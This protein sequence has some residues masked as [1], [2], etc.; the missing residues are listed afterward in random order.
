MANPALND[1]TFRNTV[2]L[3]FNAINGALQ[4]GLQRSGELPTDPRMHPAPPGDSGPPQGQP[5]YGPNADDYK[6]KLA[7]LQAR[8]YE[9]WPFVEQLLDAS[10]EDTT[11]IIDQL[12]AAS[13][14]L[15]REAPSRGFE[16]ITRIKDNCVWEGD[17]GDDFRRSYLDPLARTLQCQYEAMVSLRDLTF[18]HREIVLA[19]R[20]GLLEILDEALV[21]FKALPAQEREAY[22]EKRRQNWARLVEGAF[23]V[24]T[25][26]ATTG[27]AGGVV[28]ALVGIGGAIASDISDVDKNTDP[29]GIVDAMQRAVITLRQ[30]TA[31]EEELLVRG[32]KGDGGTQKLAEYTQPVGGRIKDMIGPGPKDLVVPS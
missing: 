22:D 10:I 8:L 21:A 11:A 16:T 3:K 18:L 26:A 28:A 14:A 4:E 2:E 9:S 6:E 29:W 27:V 5:P 32:F 13:G 24:G 15:Q 25:A 30:K 20:E 12:D 23:A 1:K 19:A 7:E 17:A 31:D